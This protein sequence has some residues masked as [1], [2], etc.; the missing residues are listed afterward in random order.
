MLAAAH[1]IKGRKIAGWPEIE[2]EVTEAG[3][4]FVDREPLTDGL[5][6]TARWP[7]D[8][9]AHMKE[10]LKVLEQSKHQSHAHAA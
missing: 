9:P 1:V 6:T 8:L 7:G 5:F 4:T 2:D 3:A 10:T